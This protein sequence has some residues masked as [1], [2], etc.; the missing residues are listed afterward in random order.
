MTSRHNQQGMGSGLQETV[1]IPANAEAPS[2]A[3]AFL[4]DHF[5]GQFRAGPTS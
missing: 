5:G 3:R 4:R 2:A 1:K